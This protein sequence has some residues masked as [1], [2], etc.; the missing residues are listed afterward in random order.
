MGSGDAPEIMQLVFQQFKSYIYLEVPQLQFIDRVLDIYSCSSEDWYAQGKLFRRW[1]IP[2]VQLFWRLLKR[3]L[4]SQRQAS[5][6]VCARLA[7]LWIHV[8]RQYFGGLAEFRFFFLRVGGIR[9]LRSTSCSPLAAGAV[10]TVDAS[11]WSIRTWKI[12]LI[13]SSPLYLR[14]YGRRRDQCSDKL[15]CEQWKCLRFSSSPELVDIFV[16]NKDGHVFSG[17]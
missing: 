2:R 11:V 17:V 13:S 1:E 14:C 6:Q 4:T 5:R 7:R 3:P 16:R 10:C 12:S 9:I 8:L 15:S